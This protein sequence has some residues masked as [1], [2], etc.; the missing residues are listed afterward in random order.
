MGELIESKAWQPADFQQALFDSAKQTIGAKQG[1]QAIY[2]AFL[3]KKSGPRAGW[4][5]LNIPAEQRQQHFLQV[6]EGK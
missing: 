3:G 6:I 2:K 1:F 5:L 4:F